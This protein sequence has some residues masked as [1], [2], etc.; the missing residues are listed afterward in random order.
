ML[1][2]AKP[3]L[4][5]RFFSRRRIPVV[6]QN[7]AAECGLACV[8]MIAKYFGDKRDLV[9]FRQHY[10][11]SLKGAT[12]K[13][14]MDI[15]LSLGLNS[16]AVKIEISDLIQLS[17]PAILH[18]NMNHFVVLE[19][20][21]KTHITVIDPAMGKCV[22][23]LNEASKHLSGIA[24]EVSYSEKFEPQENATRLKL[25][26]FLRHAVGFKRSLLTLLTLSLVLQIFALASP[27][28]MQTV[29]DDVLVYHNASLL[30]ALAIGFGFLLLIETFTNGLRKT[31]ILQL[32]SRL[33]LQLSASVFKHLLVLPLEY[34]AKRHIGDVVSRFGSLAHVRDFITT[35][36]VSAI[37]DGVM[38]LSTL[39][40]MAIYS[41]KLSVVVA[42]IMALYLCVK[43]GLLPWMR[44][45]TSE[46]INLAAAEQSHFIES[47]RAISPIR[48]YQ[49]E[50]KRHG[51]WQNKL[52]ETLNKD[53][54]LTK[55]NIGSSTANQLIFG[56]EQLIIVYIGALLVMEG[57]M[58]IGMLLAFV[59]YKTRFVGAIDNLI[60]Q[61][62]AFKML[63]LHIERLSDILHT[64]PS[65]PSSN[66]PV[67]SV[68]LD[69]TTQCD[70]LALNVEALSYRYSNSSEYIFNNLS[71]QV[72]TG[73]IIAIIGSSGSGK[74]TLLK[75]LMGLYP[76]SKGK[77]QRLPLPGKQRHVRLASV[78]Q[79]DMCLSG[80]IAQNISCFENNPNI[81]NVVYAAK[82]AC[83]H[84][85]I[86]NM[87][88]QYQSLIGDMGSSLSGGQ[89]QRL[90]LA[91]ALFQSPDILFLDEASSHL[92]L[93]N[94]R[95]INLHLKALKITRVIVAHRPQSI[96]MADTV[97]RLSDG[98][99]TKLSPSA[100]RGITLQQTSGENR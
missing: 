23:T 98:K 35:G 21:T 79:D 91:R 51:E 53:I 81:E 68:L 22:Y 1:E 100:V 83:I 59:A 70:S 31:L 96:A 88:M 50:A 7:E 29:V 39:A 5:T 3:S 78:L 55:L 10:C 80:T 99:L 42:I 37:L 26:Q 60:T 25:V 13:D 34:F 12:L 84:N 63:G 82:L 32:S 64:P 9:A 44:K 58:T 90:L 45:L 54:Q 52:V 16:R 4:H 76:L 43:L 89:K 27:Y 87:P 41:I 8:A 93:E 97:Y 57:S 67:P 2:R 40:I 94:E 38:A 73:E 6:L 72:R 33:Q 20:A 95:E 17:K 49:Q 28:Y 46:K 92:D 86:V 36:A 19:K 85:D 71:M 61:L 75:C 30:Q 14:V 56:A 47:L 65:L 74:S 18:W 24:L 15:A 69:G 62:I 48:I 11:V 66:I 77:I